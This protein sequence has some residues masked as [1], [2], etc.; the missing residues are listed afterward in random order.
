MNSHNI[1]KTHPNFKSKPHKTKIKLD[2]KNQF[3]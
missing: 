2:A 3:Y 1:K